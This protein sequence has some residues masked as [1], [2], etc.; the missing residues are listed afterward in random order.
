[1]SE[2]CIL[3]PVFGILQSTFE[4]CM[5]MRRVLLPLPLTLLA[6]CAL[7]LASQAPPK[8]VLYV[9]QSAGF[10]HDV[11]PL[12]EK[13]LTEVGR[14]HGFDVTVTGDAS[15]M[16]ARSLEAYSAVV[17]Y[18]TGELPMSDDHKAAFMAWVRSGKGFVGIHS[19]TDTFYKW[20]EYG[21]MIG[22]YF[23]EHPWNTRVTMKVEDHGHPS[24]KHLGETW[25]LADEIYQFKNYSRADKHVLLSLDVSSVDLH[26]KGVK[27]ADR[28]FAN[29]WYKSWGSG[30]VFYTALGH[31]PEVWQDP[32]FQQHLA[33]GIT[34]A[35]AAQ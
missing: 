9:T 25:A 24:T 8:R 26:A 31:R 20:P 22:G 23:D 33:G 21:E 4:S 29:A 34:W 11:L 12:S 18:T 2:S 35:M 19:A 27:R 17:F 30:R 28:D 5:T 10:K 6:T 16:T 14:T 7:L 3:H 13:I 15:T 1:M 32:A